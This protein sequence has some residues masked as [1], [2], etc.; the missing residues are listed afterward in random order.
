MYGGKG[1]EDMKYD[2]FFST[3]LGRKI[4]EEEALY[5]SNHVDGIALS[6]GCG[7]GIIEKRI[8]EI[9]DVKIIGVEINDEMIELARKRIN[10]VKANAM[11]LPFKES[12]FDTAIFITS[13]EFIED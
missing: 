7:T 2:E 5:I 10:V 11:A 12:S 3:A 6:I 8:E 4:L 1:S 9:C 13:L